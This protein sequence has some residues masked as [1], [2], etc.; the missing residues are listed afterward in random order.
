M[1]GVAEATLGFS[2][3]TGGGVDGTEGGVGRAGLGRDG[4]DGGEGSFGS[5]GT[6]V[7][8]TCMGMAHIQQGLR[9]QRCALTTYSCL[10]G[11]HGTHVDEDRA[12]W[13]M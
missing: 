13:R 1:T 3:W 11:T 6:W 2:A 7:G 4:G 10:H 8:V 5:E 12:E 9:S